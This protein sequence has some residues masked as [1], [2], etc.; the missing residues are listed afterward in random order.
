MEQT[1]ITITIQGIQYPATF[2]AKALTIWEEITDKSFFGCTFQKTS[3]REALIMAAVKTVD[4]DT[5]LSMDALL[6][7]TTYEELQEVIKAFTEIMKLQRV[8]FHLPD[9]VAEAEAKENEQVSKEE[10]ESAKN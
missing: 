7:I 2:N 5:T 1:L 8:F 3:E 4:K 9:I 6:N 10:K